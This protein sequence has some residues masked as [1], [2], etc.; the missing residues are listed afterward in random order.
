MDSSSIKGILCDI[1]GV[2]YVGDTPYPGAV[3][4]I[5]R[6]KA[7]YPIRFL[8]N[9]TQKTGAQVVANLQKMGFDIDASE[10]ITAL[11][12]TKS[13]LQQQ[14]SK[15]VLL[16]TDA[17]TKFFDDLPENPCRYV[18]VGD[19]QENFT[20]QQLNAAFRTLMHGGVLLAAA[21]NRYFKDHDGE[22]S[23]DAGPFVSA[24]EYASGKKAHI[25]G[26]P[27]HDFYHLACASIGVDPRNAVMIG[28]DIQSD[29]SGAQEAGLQAILVRTGKFSPSDLDSSIV[30]DAVFDSLADI[31]L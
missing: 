12:V 23:M 11:D 8:T 14:H 2:L 29:I 27:S 22:L 24:L 25:I 5:N 6:L 10:V 20:Y 17:A 3:E 15:A 30:P 9:T 26:K 7:S 1:G 13:Y 21:N 19:A 28:D 31:V 18:V 16:L 4:A